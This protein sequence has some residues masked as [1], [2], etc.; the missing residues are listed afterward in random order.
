MYFNL[1]SFA[2]LK[3]LSETLFSSTYSWGARLRPSAWTS[4][5]TAAVNA[6]VHSPAP[7]VNGQ[8]VASQ[9]AD[10][11]ST[12]QQASPTPPEHRSQLNQLPVR[13]H[14]VAPRLPVV[15]CH[16]L[17]GFDTLG[18]ESLPS[19]RIHYWR[20]IKEAMTDVG[21]KVHVTRVPSSGSIAQRAEELH[22]QL[23]RWFNGQEINLL[24]HSMGGL[25]GRYL[26]SHIQPS[27][28]R[29]RSLSTVCTP[30]RGSPFMDWCRDIFGVGTI[31]S[32]RR[33]GNF[34]PEEAWLQQYGQTASSATHDN[35]LTSH[36]LLTNPL[37]AWQL[38]YQK[39]AG[40]LDTPAYSNLTTEFCN[41][42]FNPS[43]PNHPDT[44]YFSY[45]A[46]YN[47]KIHTWSSLRLPYE[48]IR[49]REGPNDGMVSLY[50]ARWGQYMETV[51]ADH[52]DVT[53]PMKLSELRDW[54]SSSSLMATLYSQLDSLL[55]Y[56]STSLT[57]GSS[58]S[59]PASG[60]GQ[61]NPIPAH[62]A[63]ATMAH[64]TQMAQHLANESQRP[65]VQAAVAD[66][67][68]DKLQRAR[69][70]GPFDAI[71]FYL[72]MGTHLYNQGY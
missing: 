23:R 45:G 15:L 42:F 40:L 66:Q 20:G 36:L 50:S 53:N 31:A 6:L 25:D 41:Q 58:N 46:S 39:I 12:T 24:G 72:R 52:Y 30:H 32:N 38:F 3:S 70:Q 37:R 59:R 54:I 63:A 8:R 57:K 13:P 61:S 1:H 51:S 2:S 29:V 10:S 33:T 64:I 14:Y 26:I 11:T 49:K 17:Y 19:L 56:Y 48:I 71:D 69:Q 65:S 5:S 62:E 16:G 47:P 22:S 18:P 55:S 4:R 27:E 21:A 34:D 28:Y 68:H 67:A 9:V 60:L 43:T 35:P 7:V 44:A